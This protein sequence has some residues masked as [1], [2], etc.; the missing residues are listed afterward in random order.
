VRVSRAGGL[1]VAREARRLA[2]ASD[3]WSETAVKV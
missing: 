1:A 3:A 2:L